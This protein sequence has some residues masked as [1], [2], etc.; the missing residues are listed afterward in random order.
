MSRPAP[1][2]LKAAI[3]VSGLVLL[4]AGFSRAERL[5]AGDASRPRVPGD[6]AAET[7]RPSAATPESIAAAKDAISRAITSYGNDIRDA[8]H[9]ELIR[10]P[11]IAG[12][13]AV[14]FKVRP[15]GDVDDVRIDR[16]SLN[17]PPLE[18]EIVTRI[19]AWKF[20]PFEGEPVPANVPYRFGPN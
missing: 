1:R 18:E 9:R 20:P 13:V 5:P 15:A 3:V 19:K 7:A 2:T 4:T 8:Y 10:N 17:W 11:K 12:D 6:N 14:S 16:S